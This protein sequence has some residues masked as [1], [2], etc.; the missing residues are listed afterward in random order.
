MR[1]LL[2]LLAFGLA[3]VVLAQPVTDTEA[4][5]ASLERI[6]ASEHGLD[7]VTGLGLEDLEEIHEALEEEE[8][9]QRRCRLWAGAGPRRRCVRWG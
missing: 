1:S 3:T 5:E 8:E 4:L 7:E 2:V 6:Y 9:K